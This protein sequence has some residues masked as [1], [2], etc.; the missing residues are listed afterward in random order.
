MFNDV[1]S[2]I[3]V[4]GYLYGYLTQVFDNYNLY[5]SAKAPNL[6]NNARYDNASKN[7][8]MGLTI[9][10]K[11]VHE[12]HIPVD[13][14]QLSSLFDEIEL[15]KLPKNLNITQQ[16]TWALGFTAGKAANFNK[17]AIHRKA[18]K[19]SQTQ[20]AELANIPVRN[21]KAYEIGERKL[22]LASAETVDKLAKALDCK[23][24]DLI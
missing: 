3:Y 13:Q 4:T 9:A 22:H 10:I 6:A 20:L 7:P 24:E 18:K 19:L 15:D 17:L 23:I 14:K 11:F 8:M 16:G 2:Q 12:L 21:I 1:N 5:H